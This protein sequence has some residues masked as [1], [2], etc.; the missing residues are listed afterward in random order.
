MKYIICLAVLFLPLS[1]LAQLF[2]QIEGAVGLS[3]Q[4]YTI[5]EKTGF[6]SFR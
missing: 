1:C 3:V 6:Q 5:S 4:G 2:D